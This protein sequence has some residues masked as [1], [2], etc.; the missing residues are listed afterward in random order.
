MEGLVKGLPTLVMD[1]LTKS[2]PQQV[3]ND[4]N[5]STNYSSKRNADVS[6]NQNEKIGGLQEADTEGISVAE[7]LHHYTPQHP[8]PEEIKKLA[9]DDTV[10]KYCGV[11][12]LIHN[13][14]KKLED[15]L[16]EAEKELT[17]L[18]GQKQREETMKD[19]LNLR[20]QQLD[21]LNTAMKANNSLITS[22]NSEVLALKDRIVELSDE[23]LTTKKKYKNSLRKLSSSTQAV[24]QQRQSLT[25]LS[26]DVKKGQSE[27]GTI[28]KSVQEYF[29]LL[30]NTFFDEKSKLESQLQCTDMER[31]VLT[32]ANKTLTDKLNKAESNVKHLQADI[33]VK[34]KEVESL[35]TSICQVESELCRFKEVADSLQA[36][37]K[38]LTDTTR[39]LN[40]K[41]TRCKAL[42]IELD[43]LKAELRIK[44]SEICNLETANKQQHQQHEVQCHK[45]QREVK[46]KEDELSVSLKQLKTWEKKWLD[47]QK[48]QAEIL[49][50]S[51]LSKN[52]TD[53][54]RD[55]LNQVKADIEA[56]KSEREMMIGAHQ[57]RIEELRESFKQKM[58]EVENWPTKLQGAVAAEKTRHLHEIKSLEE[59]LKHNFVLEL[60]IEKDKYNKLLSQFHKQEQDK[61]NN[62]YHELEAIE[63]KF[64]LQ[65]EQTQSQLSDCSNRAKE[66][67][68]DLS[69][70]I[71]SLKKI[72]RDLQDRLARL[73]G[74]DTG[75]VYDLQKKLAS[76]QKEWNDA[77]TSV[78]DLE[79][80]LRESS[81]QNQF[82]QNIV[83]K[84]CE[85]RFELT[86]ALNEARKELLQLKKPPGGFLPRRGSVVSLQS[87]AS[88]GPHN[89]AGEESLLKLRTQMPAN[90]VKLDYVGTDN[91]RTVGGAGD[92]MA[93]SRKRIANMMGR[94]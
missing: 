13:E 21:G 52:E 44:S 80:K 40:E 18:R 5:S 12:Y 14:I 69:A 58:A 84:E 30:K 94:I 62:R 36:E 38:S 9:R 45:L 59:K 48:H 28:L 87:G 39:E 42:V 29:V 7:E 51:K 92:Q 70:E 61:E 2:E 78:N 56:L 60:Q 32:E 4:S 75:K 65:L 83:Q 91:M 37:R 55:H 24:R 17:L 53:D 11:S 88:P 35:K 16:R 64:K 63:H 10:C 8:L 25:Q 74:E 31:T 23:N 22:L 66:R 85:E 6:S 67:E 76:C 47:Q 15:K 79:D 77:L 50:Q 57:N 72:I 90:N 1:N 73:D 71:G 34:E 54:V 20:E 93:D 27:V 81:Q 3:K 46:C 19:Q 82:L 86:E 49:Q 89:V 26:S 33:G 68:A 41:E 43:E